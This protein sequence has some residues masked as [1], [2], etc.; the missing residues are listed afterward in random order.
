MP[1]L[2]DATPRRSPGLPVV[3]ATLLAT[4]ATLPWARAA[5]ASASPG[6]ADVVALGGTSRANLSSPAGMLTAAATLPL[7]S[8]YEIQAA[9]LLGPDKLVGVRAYAMDSSTGPVALGLSYHYDHWVPQTEDADLPGWVLPD[10]DLSNEQGRTTF[11]GGLATSFAERRVGLGLSL[12]WNNAASRFG[13]L[14]QWLTGGLSLAGRFGE[15]EQLVVSLAADNMLTP[16]RDDSPLT[17]GFGASTRPVPAF[18][19]FGQVDAVT[20][21]FDRPVDL[22]LGLGVEGVA[23]E[24]VAVRAG[25]RRDPD[26]RS[27]VV[28]MGIGARSDQMSIDY[29]AE[30]VVGHAG[31]P[32]AGWDDGKLRSYHTL[33]VSLSF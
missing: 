31:D 3:A 32:P 22:G 5:R 24:V 23:A 25:L 10:D 18:G 11:G 16:G 6:G 8:R 30:L 20:G 21:A 15:E 33:S 7:S 14:Q 19:V 27:D 9:G 12:M 13:D 4:V 26:R 28:T 29:A 2:H 17:F 1:G